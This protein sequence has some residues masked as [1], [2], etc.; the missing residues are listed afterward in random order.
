MQRISYQL[1]GYPNNFAND[2]YRQAKQEAEWDRIEQRMADEK[3]RAE[4]RD[5]EMRAEYERFQAQEI[6]RREDRGELLR[7]TGKL[8]YTD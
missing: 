4:Q 7:N 8:L 5:R 2:P 1:F 3:A 6:R